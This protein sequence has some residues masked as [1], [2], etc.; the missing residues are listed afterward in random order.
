MDPCRTFMSAERP[1]PPIHPELLRRLRE[2]FPNDIKRLFHST[3]R[4]VGVAIGQQEV[5]AKLDAWSQDAAKEAL[6]GS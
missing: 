4:Q 6:T 5:I 3:D 1:I 2:I